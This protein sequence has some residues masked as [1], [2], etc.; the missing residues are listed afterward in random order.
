MVQIKKRLLNL[1]NCQ[2]EA[3]KENHI[4]PCIKHFPGDGVD[5]RDQHLLSSVNDLTVN[6]WNNSYGKIYQHF[7]NN[8]I[9]S[10]M[11]GHILLPHYIKEINPECNEEDYMQQ[12]YQKRF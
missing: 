10:I 3:L 12:V 1:L 11:V 4:L 5:M 6:K 9:G 8:G 7:I 2:I